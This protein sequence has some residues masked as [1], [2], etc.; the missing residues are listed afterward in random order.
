MFRKLAIFVGVL[1]LCGGIA[2]GQSTF[3]TLVGIVTD[4]TGAVVPNATV[5]ATHLATNTSKTM[6]TDSSGSFELLNLQ[7]GAYNVSV[8]AAGFKEIVQ[9]NIPLDPRAIVRVNAVLQVGATQT[10]IE[11]KGLVPVITTETATVSSMEG[12]EQINQLPINTRAL[13]TS[14]LNVIT[15]L[16]GVQVDSRGIAGG[17]ISLAGMRPSQAEFS[18]DGFSTESVRNNGAEVEMYPSTDGISEVKVTTQ[19]AN[20]EQS[21]MGD[22]SF[23]GKGG[24]NHFHGALF[25]YLQND[26]LDAI[27]AF[28]HGKPPVR[29]NSFG[30]SIG[31]PVRLPH[32]N[33]KDRTF[34]FFDWES[35]RQHASSAVT[36]N[37]PTAAELTGDFSAL[38]PGTQLVNPFTGAPYTNNQIDPT[39]WSQ[40]SKKMLATF[41]PSSNSQTGG[42]LNASNDFRYNFA[43]PVT[44]NQFDVRIDQNISKKQSIFGR[45]SY[46]KLTA[47][48]P[49]G[50]SLGNKDTVENPKT[51]VV[52]YNYAITSNL[53]NEARFGYS[54]QE[55]LTT[56]PKFPNGATLVTQT[57]GLQQLASPFPTGSAI[58]GLSFQGDS[59]ITSISGTRQRPLTEG[60][61]QIADNLTWIR[62]RHT[63]KFGFDVRAL[64][65]GDY[66]NFNGPDN[67]G[68]FYFQGG[69]TGS[70]LADF[71]LGLP[72]YTEVIA[73]GPD[74]KARGKAYG[75]FGQDSIK[76]TSKLTI[77]LGLRYEYHPPLYDLTY[78][79]TQFDPATGGFIVPDDGA[80]LTT[81]AF[82][83]GVNACGLATPVPTPYGLYPCTPYELASKVHVPQALRFGDKTKI[84]PRA[85]FAYRISDKTVVRAGAG[86]YDMTLL[87]SIFNALTSVS[88]SNYQAFY[89]SFTGGVPLIQFP[90]T[91][92]NTPSTGVSYAGGEAFGT[93]TDIHLRDP[94]A[95]Q[96]SLSV[97]RDLGRQT[98]LRVTYNGLRSVGLIVSPDLNQIP[99]PQT[100]PYSPTEK[101]YPNWSK[102]KTLTNGGSQIYNALETAVTHRFS[103]GFFIQ[104][105]W[106]WAKNLSDGEGD[107]PGSF[108][109]DYGARLND[110]FD[111][112]RNYGNLSFTRRH[113]WLTTAV[114]DIPVGRGMKYGSTMNPVLNGIIGGWRTSNIITLET[115]PFLTPYYSGSADPSGTGAPGREGAQRPDRLPASACSGLPVSEGQVFGGSCFYYGWPGPI[116]RFGNSGV[117]IITGPGTAV[118]DFGLSKNF[119]LTEALKLRF[120][121]TFTNFLNHVNYAVPNMVSNSASFGTISG[122]QTAEGASA[123]VIQFALRLDF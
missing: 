15:T 14:P 62:G 105:N 52:S 89:N 111:L 87:G 65:L 56:Y 47:A 120:E 20:A 43:A 29:D 1:F 121:G 84:L 8:K 70:D 5:T 113:R 109:G 71:L 74:Y 6:S 36:Q 58:P 91:E 76:V 46:K 55:T 7:P 117:G 94:Y 93:A 112:H 79:I 26:A 4:P 95:E 32:Y 25:D 99:Q 19:L 49:M 45:I 66:S 104:S 77:N 18:V 22:V 35:N 75:F 68:Y 9:Q 83:Q 27:P 16:A 57:L 23:I 61:Y 102:V 38:L 122:V 80:K 39:T 92:S 60:R 115:G 13:D 110:H 108:N 50:L 96:W 33:G 72:T 97:E 123:R 86:M 107:N 34:F 100:T 54:Y 2:L 24:S 28:A 42:P 3:G 21:Q 85:N 119:R 44:S 81:L 48:S 114:V 73:A 63:M 78:Q 37:V 88:S 59:G 101:P 106:T 40:T 103:A 67:F 116:G 30:G 90:N 64:E 82:E 118:W 51:F 69:Y 53:L 17:G 12:S 10:T 11:V 98:G 31:G 41:Y